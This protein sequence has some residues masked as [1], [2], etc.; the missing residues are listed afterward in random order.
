M[1]YLVNFLLAAKRNFTSTVQYH[2]VEKNIF[3]FQS[4]KQNYITL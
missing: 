3:L 4:T 1:F 2:Y